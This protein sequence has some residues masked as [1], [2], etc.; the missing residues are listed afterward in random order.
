MKVFLDQ[1]YTKLWANKDI[2]TEVEKLDGN[3]FR[4][5]KNRRTLQFTQD[6]KSYFLKHH[7]GVGW[8]EIFKNLFN[9]KLPIISARNEYLAIRKLESLNIDTMYCGAYGERKFNPAQ[10]ES[11]IITGDL[12]NSISLED[13]TKDW[14]NT[15]PKREFKTALIERLAK[16]SRTL[17]DNG[18]NHRDYYL[19]HFL[20]TNPEC[21]TAKDFHIHLIDL[22]RAAIR[23]KIPA[24][25]LFK[26]MGGLWFSA[27]DIN[28]SKSDVL[29][30]IE[31]YSGKKWQ[32]ELAENSCFWL[33]I[34]Q[35]AERLYQK[36]FSRMPKHCFSK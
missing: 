2:F 34:N 7:K 11:F 32:D 31:F 29:R 3:V 1:F 12:G 36:D 30:F 4:N 18:I 9:F 19:C 35:V 20:L 33:K 13:L 17:H 26:D 24:R 28:L 21:A 23:H 6:G 5:I 15:P 25:Y 10:R 22:H 27:M 8:R 14:A 16:V